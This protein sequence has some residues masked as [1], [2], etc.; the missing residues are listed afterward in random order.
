MRLVSPLI[1]VTT[2][3]F[4]T[5]A[6]VCLNPISVDVNKPEGGNG[7]SGR[8]L[9]NKALGVT[10]GKWH[11]PII[12]LLGKITLRYAE[13]GDPLPL[14]SGR[15]LADE[16]KALLLRGVL[17]QQAYPEVPP[18]VEYAITRRG[19]LTFT[20]P[21]ERSWAALFAIARR[22]NQLINSWYQR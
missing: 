17:R 15:V 18:R 13:L 8:L 16:L 19:L 20:Y 9:I 1:L 3:R 2:N 21:T 14:V 5:T 4:F 10:R 7:G 12:R 6:S 11:L 22:T